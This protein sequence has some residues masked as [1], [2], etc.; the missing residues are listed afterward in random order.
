[1]TTSLQP[2]VSRTAVSMAFSP[3][4]CADCG[5]VVMEASSG[6]GRPKQRH[7]KTY[8]FRVG[9]DWP[10]RLRH[11]RS[12]GLRGVRLEVE[13]RRPLGALGVA[14][15]PVSPELSSQ[16]W[17][18]RCR[19]DRRGPQENQRKNMIRRGKKE[20]KEYEEEDQGGGG[21]G[22]EKKVYVGGD[23]V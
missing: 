22:G 16:F 1:M 19:A 7:P 3:N 21:T 14:A 23:G 10:H 9:R 12:S 5:A 18:P 20:K 17:A 11:L 15:R 4:T 8:G 13:V 6:R 2:I